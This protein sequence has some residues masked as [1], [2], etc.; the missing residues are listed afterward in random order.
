M[1]IQNGFVSGGALHIHDF[2][3]L[4]VEWLVKNVTYRP[5]CYMCVTGKQSMRFLFSSQWPKP[6]PHCSPWTLLESLRAKMVNH[7]DLDNR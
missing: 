3:M 7:T 2:S 6:L 1:I 4:D 5:H